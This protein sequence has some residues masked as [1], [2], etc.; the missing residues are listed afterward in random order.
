MDN[1]KDSKSEY[2]KEK[3]RKM[4]ADRLDVSLPKMN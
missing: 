1:D 3:D 4:V 2:N